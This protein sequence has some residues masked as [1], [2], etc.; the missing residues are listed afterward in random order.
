MNLKKIIPSNNG[1]IFICDDN[2]G[3]IMKNKILGQII[4][5]KTNFEFNFEEKTYSCGQY[6][7]VLN[8][9]ENSKIIDTNKIKQKLKCI[10]SQIHT[11]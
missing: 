8:I 7:N 4:D 9:L 10:T 11:N 3:V 6:N 2:F 1:F 5:L